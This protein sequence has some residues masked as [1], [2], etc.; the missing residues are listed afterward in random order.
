MGDGPLIYNFNCMRFFFKRRKKGNCGNKKGI[1]R[2]CNS[3]DNQIL[4]CRCIYTW[5]K[6]AHCFVC[7]C[8]S[9][10]CPKDTAKSMP[11]PSCIAEITFFQLANCDI[12]FNM[13]YS[14][15]NYFLYSFFVIIHIKSDTYVIFFSSTQFLHPALVAKCEFSFSAPELLVLFTGPTVFHWMYIFW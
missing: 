4:P 13:P 3:R 14:T 7:N 11:K 8:Y 5:M 15:A 6:T 10:I 2:K 9:Q 1:W 12:L